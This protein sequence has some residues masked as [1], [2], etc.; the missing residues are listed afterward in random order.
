MCVAIANE[1]KK[2]HQRAIMQGLLT[3]QGPE[4]DFYFEVQV[5]IEVYACGG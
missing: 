2:M 3:P 5:I 1:A 4:L